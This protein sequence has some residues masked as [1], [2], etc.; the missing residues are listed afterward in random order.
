MPGCMS[1]WPDKLGNAPS[2]RTSTSVRTF[3]ISR[4][5]GFFL[6]PVS[7]LVILLLEL[8]GKVKS[9][10]QDLETVKVTFGRNA[11]ELAKSL[12]ER[13]ALE[14]ELDQIHNVAQLVV[15]EVFGSAPSTTAP[16]VQLAEV[17]DE[18]WSLITH[19]L[20][21]G[22]SGVLTSVATYHPNL[23]FTTIYSGYADGLSTKDIQMLEES[24]LPYARLVA[25]QVSA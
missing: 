2:L 23:D 16:A 3:S 11:E 6:Q 7:E 8:G 19:G 9:L 14:G 17:S 20:F 18:V 24:L 1:R 22:A 13:R 4:R 12:K 21:Y 10:E 25:E 15:S 5:I